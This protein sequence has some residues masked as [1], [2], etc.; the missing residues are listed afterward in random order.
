MDFHQKCRGRHK[1]NEK[2]DKIHVGALLALAGWLV[3]NPIINI[4]LAY[5]LVNLQIYLSY[6]LAQIL[7]LFM[8]FIVRCRR[9][10]CNAKKK[11]CIYVEHVFSFSTKAI[12]QTC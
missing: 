10:L 4:I 12:K 7:D 5:E 11:S 6:T 2:D 3:V 8:H 9:R 1:T